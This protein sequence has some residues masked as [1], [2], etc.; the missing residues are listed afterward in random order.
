MCSWWGSRTAARSSSTVCF[1]QTLSDSCPS[2]THP[3]LASLVSNTAWYLEDQGDTR[4]HAQQRLITLNVENGLKPQIN[5]ITQG[6]LQFGEKV[7][8]SCFFFFLKLLCQE[9]KVS[10]CMYLFILNAISIST[11]QLWTHSHWYSHQCQPISLIRV[12]RKE[13]KDGAIDQ[14]RLH[15]WAIGGR[16]QPSCCL[17]HPTWGTL[18]KK[19]KSLFYNSIFTLSQ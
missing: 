7:F 16:A 6:A 11:W 5:Q 1:C 10:V 18:S 12:T 19:Y 15:G 9:T 3:P 14:T 4:T 2:F 13:K 8:G 17:L